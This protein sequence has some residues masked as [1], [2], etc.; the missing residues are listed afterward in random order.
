[1]NK[2]VHL[3]DKGKAGINWCRKASNRKNKKSP[4]AGLPKIEADCF[5]PIFSKEMGFFVKDSCLFGGE[6]KGERGFGESLVGLHQRNIYFLRYTSLLCPFFKLLL[7]QI[8]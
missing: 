3:S 1:M 7:F 6:K 4:V 5:K 2:C 8:S